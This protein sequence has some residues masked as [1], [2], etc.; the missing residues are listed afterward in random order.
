MDKN[1]YPTYNNENEGL[2]DFNV[3]A[4]MDAFEKVNENS[5]DFVDESELANRNVDEN[6]DGPEAVR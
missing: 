5:V 3:L 4:S 1:I 2:C 6:V